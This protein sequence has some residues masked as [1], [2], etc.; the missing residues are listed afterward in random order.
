MSTIPLQRYFW[1]GYVPLDMSLHVVE[2]LLGRKMA[3]ETAR[4]MEYR[5]NEGGE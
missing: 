5:W 4:M 3:E 1:P 2:R